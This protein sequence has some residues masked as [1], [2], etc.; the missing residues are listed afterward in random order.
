[1]L[2][3]LDRMEGYLYISFRNDTVLEHKLYDDIGLIMLER[4]FNIDEAYMRM[5]RVALIARN[6]HD[7]TCSYVIL[8]T[9][10]I[11]PDEA[12]TSRARHAYPLIKQAYREMRLNKIGI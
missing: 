2:V 10:G 6:R 8:L 9:G 7:S 4:G 11:N 12:P 5:V 3:I 1:M